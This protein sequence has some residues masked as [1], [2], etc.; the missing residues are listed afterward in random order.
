V[1][2]GGT[3]TTTTITRMDC[4]RVTGATGSPSRWARM[5][6]TITPPGTEA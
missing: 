4:A 3:V 1:T 6:I 2:T 5:A